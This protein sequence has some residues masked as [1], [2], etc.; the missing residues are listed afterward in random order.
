MGHPFPVHEAPQAESLPRVYLARHGETAWS[1]SGRHSGR[2]DLPLT[3]HG[4]D[5]ARRLASR[6]ARIAFR[7]VFTSPLTRVRRTCELAGFGSGTVMDPDLL[8]W[9]YGAYQGKTPAEIR[10][11]RP[12]W[13]IFRDGCPQ[14]ELLAHVAARA[15]HVVARVRALADDV[16]IFSSAHLLRVLAARWLGLDA[17]LGRYLLLDTTAVSVLS[18]QRDLTEPVIR[19]WND[20]RHLA[21]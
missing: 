2:I 7:Q 15:D 12:G 18:Y 5:N 21:A 17:T 9:D 14:G 10:S 1:L 11:E 16:L 8:E 13:E 3:P 4:E 19:L 6:L 20:Q